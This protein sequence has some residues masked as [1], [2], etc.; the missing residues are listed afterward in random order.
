M[1]R[2]GRDVTM[3]EHLEKKKK[4][5]SFG[6]AA[7]RRDLGVDLSLRLADELRVTCVIYIRSSCDIPVPSCVRRPSPITR[8][9]LV[10]R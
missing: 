6:R 9:T 4:H 8:W 5:S 3:A 2:R 7:K 1:T 10:A